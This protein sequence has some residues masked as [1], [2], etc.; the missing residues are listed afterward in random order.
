MK[1]YIAVKYRFLNTIYNVYLFIDKKARP[2][3]TYLYILKMKYI[4]TLK[5]PTPLSNNLKQQ[6][7]LLF[8]HSFLWRY[9]FS[10]SYSFQ[11]EWLSWWEVSSFIIQPPLLFFVLDLK[12]KHKKRSNLPLKICSLILVWWICATLTFHFHYHSHFVTFLL[13][14]LYVEIMY[15]AFVASI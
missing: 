1:L 9:H 15:K 4:I 8:L 13:W 6:V 12:K 11:D 7:G 3:L 10:C 14:G 2:G 5:G